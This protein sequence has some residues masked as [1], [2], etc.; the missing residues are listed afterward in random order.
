MT[1]LTSLWTRPKSEE[2]ANIRSVKGNLRVHNAPDN[3]GVEGTR[4]Y[5]VLHIDSGLRIS[6]HITAV[7]TLDSSWPA[8]EVVIALTPIH[9]NPKKIMTVQGNYN[10]FGMSRELREICP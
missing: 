2:I 7:P 10:P 6:Y 9:L 5:V 3:E 1:E 8:L 4:I